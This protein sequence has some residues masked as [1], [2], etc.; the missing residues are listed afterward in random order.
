MTLP[1]NLNEYQPALSKD[2]APALL[3]C[4]SEQDLQCWHVVFTGTCQDD[5]AFTTSGHTCVLKY[6]LYLK[7]KFSES[8]SA[9]DAEGSWMFFLIVHIVIG[10]TPYVI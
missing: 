5:M 3:F 6:K 2:P 4:N 9:D 8:L 7:C 1:P 10:A